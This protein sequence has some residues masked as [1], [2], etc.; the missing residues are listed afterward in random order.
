VDLIELTR[1]HFAA[2]IDLKARCAGPLAGPIVRAAAEVFGC[3]RRGGKI[4]TC[5]NGGSAADAQHFAAEM[6]NRFELERPGLAALALTTDSSI[7][8]SIANDSAFENVF[9]RQ[10]GALAHTGDLLLAITTSG[11]SDNICRSIQRAHELGL[12]VVALTGRGGGNL[13][14]L[15]HP[16]DVEIR[17]PGESTARIQEVH[18]LVIHCLC[19]LVDQQIQNSGSVIGNEE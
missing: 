1:H 12:I 6:V 8:T 19:D 13:A 15:L 2:S 11:N 18:V 3:L 9:S 17:V 7:L 5:G 4:L 16:Q 10:L 14:A